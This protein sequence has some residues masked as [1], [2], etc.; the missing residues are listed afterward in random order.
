[1]F[2]VPYHFLIVH[3]PIVLII[4]AAFC[5]LRKAHDDGYRLNLWAAL[6]AGLAIVTGLILTG[7]RMAHVS[8]HA[9]AGIIGGI[10]TVILAVLRYS[11][12]ARGEDANVF[13]TAWL[14]VELLGLLAIL[15]AALTGHR[16]R[17]GF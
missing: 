4:G 5:D 15:A 10:V 14:L 11:Q 1:M 16:A 13:P 17:L 7:G 12:R 9:G 6:G 2:G 8:A 3:F